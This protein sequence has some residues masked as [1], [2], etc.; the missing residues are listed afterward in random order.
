MIVSYTPAQHT[1]GHS[2]NNLPR[3]NAVSTK[4]N[5]KEV[6]TW[7]K[8]LTTTIK[9]LDSQN[10]CPHWRKAASLRETSKQLSSCQASNMNASII[11]HQITT[12][13]IE[14]RRCDFD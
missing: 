1:A 14:H 11:L 7:K 6:T 5:C 10:S 12:T 4:P 9:T 3:K 2:W 13:Y 8:T